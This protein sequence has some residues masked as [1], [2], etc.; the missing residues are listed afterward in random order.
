M[1]LKPN[2]HRNTENRAEDISAPEEVDSEMPDSEEPVDNEIPDLDELDSDIRTVESDTSETSE[3][4]K[5]PT[6]KTLFRYFRTFSDE[7]YLLVFNTLGCQK[8]DIIDTIQKQR[9]DRQPIDQ[10]DEFLKRAVVMAN[11]DKA[12]DDDKLKRKKKDAL[13]FATEIWPQIQDLSELQ[14][15]AALK[16]YL[17]LQY[18]MKADKKW[19]I[20]LLQVINA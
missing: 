6:M 4:S 16:Y 15:I 7:E 19:L 11:I 3:K 18:K 13:R 5:V 1:P 10:Q 14:D 9:E 2:D 12:F 8:T 20:T 17:E